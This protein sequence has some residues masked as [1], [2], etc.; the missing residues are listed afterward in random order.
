MTD[1]V[2]ADNFLKDVIE[3]SLDRGVNLDEI[4]FTMPSGMRCDW[5]QW[6]FISGANDE[7]EE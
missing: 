7:G 6:S 2:T 3:L 1:K 5:G 4:K